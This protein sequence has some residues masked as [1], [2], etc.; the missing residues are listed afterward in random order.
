MIVYQPS[1]GAPKDLSGSIVTALKNLT[2]DLWAVSPEIDGGGSTL[3]ELEKLSQIAQDEKDK[4][5]P[6]FMH[7]LISKAELI[8][9]YNLEDEPG[10]NNVIKGNFGEQE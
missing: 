5:H 10:R 3:K 1:E 2:G 8:K 4:S 6:I 7:S 9:I